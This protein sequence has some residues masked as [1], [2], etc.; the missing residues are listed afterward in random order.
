MPVRVRNSKAKS[1]APARVVARRSPAA[2]LL[3]GDVEAQGASAAMLCFV[4]HV[5]RKGLLLLMCILHR[6]VNSVALSL[7]L[8]C[9]PMHRLIGGSRSLHSTAWDPKFCVWQEL[10]LG[11]HMPVKASPRAWCASAS[12]CSPG[13]PAASCGSR[14][15]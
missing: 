7:Q 6:T 13:S 2:G 1:A 3:R 12:V 10:L 15:A 4:C 9:K 8:Q 14:A 11:V 5:D